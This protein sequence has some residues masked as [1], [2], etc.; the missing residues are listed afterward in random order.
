M[1]L[2]AH[3]QAK[4]AVLRQEKRPGPSVMGTPVA[5]F[6]PKDGQPL[7]IASGPDRVSLGNAADAYAAIARTQDG[8]AMLVL[9]ATDTSKWPSGLRAAFFGAGNRSE[10]AIRTMQNCAFDQCFAL[11]SA[12]VTKLLAD[13]ARTDWVY[14]RIGPA[15]P[16]PIPTTGGTQVSMFVS[17]LR[18]AAPQ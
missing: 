9:F 17:D 10:E 2:Q 16:G 4:G 5:V 14:T 13:R 3:A 7:S 8:G 1:R 15:P 11:T 18:D 12:Q 6:T